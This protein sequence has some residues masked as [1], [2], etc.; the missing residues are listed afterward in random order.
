MTSYFWKTVLYVLGFAPLIFCVFI[1]AFYFHCFYILGRFPIL[2]IDDPK[3][4]PLYYYFSIVIEYVAL[5][6]FYLFPVWVVCSIFL[7]LKNRNHLFWRPLFISA[8]LYLIVIGI[9]I[10]NILH[11]FLGN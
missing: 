1:L 5:L 3:G 11:W 2:S 8:V 4:I 7:V 6:V 10:S 9:I